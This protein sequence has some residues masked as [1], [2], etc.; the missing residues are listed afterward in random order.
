MNTEEAILKGKASL[1]HALCCCGMDEHSFDLTL[2]ETLIDDDCEVGFT[3]TVQLKPYS[4]DD[5]LVE[6]APVTFELCHAKDSDD[7]YLIVGEDDEWDITYGNVFA[8][9]YFT[10]I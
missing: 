6:P 7:V 9:M 1:A 4:T 5:G 2:T 10:V 3:V 8:Y